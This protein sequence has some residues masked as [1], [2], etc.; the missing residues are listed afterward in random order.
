MSKVN[1][2]IMK[3]TMAVFYFNMYYQ[4]KEILT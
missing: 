1:V 2:E 3:K 4:S